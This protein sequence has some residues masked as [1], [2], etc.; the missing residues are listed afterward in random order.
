MG[1][2]SPDLRC[3]YYL[4]MGQEMK[5]FRVRMS[6]LK[7]EY[8]TSLSDFHFA[9]GAGG[10]W[11]INIAPDGLP[12]VHPRTRQPGNLRADGEVAVSSSASGWFANG[13]DQFSPVR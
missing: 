4:T 2:I 9:A 3:I 1:T 6:D 10:Y 11:T 7:S 12:F 5:L 8:L 13:Y